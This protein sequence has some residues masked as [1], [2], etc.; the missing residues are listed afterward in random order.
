MVE[1]SKFQNDPQ[2]LW[3]KILEAM[4]NRVP[5]PEFDTWIF[6]TIG[7][8]KDEQTFVILVI[9]DS[10][11]GSINDKYVNLYIQILKEVTDQEFMVE[12]FSLEGSINDYRNY[13]DKKQVLKYMLLMCKGVELSLDQVKKIH[14]NIL[15]MFNLHTPDEVKEQEDKC[16]QSLGNTFD[17]GNQ[18][19]IITKPKYRRTNVKLPTITESPI[20]Q[21]MRRNNKKII[22]ELKRLENG[23]FGLFRLF[24]KCHK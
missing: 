12:V 20:T 16:V 10:M 17:E 15:S 24:R 5:K 19:V 18:E 21:K 13:V 7:Q 14:F 8:L 9:D 11:K 1:N 6:P 2:N 23:P 4:Y 22:M 3:G